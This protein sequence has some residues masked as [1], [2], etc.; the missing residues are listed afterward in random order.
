MSIYARSVSSEIV[1]F[2]KIYEIVP[3]VH[4][5]HIYL[6]AYQNNFTSFYFI[7]RPQENDV[8]PCIASHVNTY[9]ALVLKS[10]V[11]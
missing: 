11:L 9:F 10:S 2:N 3:K 5:M 4:I 7:T 1:S 8:H 6:S